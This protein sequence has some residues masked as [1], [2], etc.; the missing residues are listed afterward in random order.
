MTVGPILFLN[1]YARTQL[2]EHGE[3]VT[4][5][6]D[7]TTGSTWWT[8]EYG[9]CKNGD[10]IVEH[11]DEAEPT[12]AALE[13]FQSLSGFPTTAAWIDAIEELHGGGSGCLYRVTEVEE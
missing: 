5:R 1:E 6:G 12:A 7:R 10:C 9:T 11:V 2:V 8:D 13:E 4:F 3:V